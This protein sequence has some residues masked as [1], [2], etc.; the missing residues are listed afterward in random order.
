MNLDAALERLSRDPQ[1]SLDV[2]EVSLSL[3]RDE[4][5]R[6]DVE[7]CL[8]EIVSMAHEARRYV[9]GDLPG[10]VQ[11]LCRYLFHDMGFRGNVK[12]YYDPLNSYFN[13][14][15]ER[16]TGIPITLSALVMAVGRRAGLQV[17][18]IGLPGHFIVRVGDGAGSLLVDPFHGGRQLSGTDCENLVRQA[19]GAPIALSPLSLE[20]IPLGLMLRRMLNNLKGIYL[21]LEDFARAIR[22]MERM[23]QL[24]PRDAVLRRD[25]GVSLVRT[26]QPGKALDHLRYYIQEAPEA[27]D[28]KAIGAVLRDAEKRVAQ[29][30]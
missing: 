23:L 4:Y 27:D 8:G 30:N 3:A 1:A 24:N 20:P 6:L 25:L 29:W 2:A 5:P 22:I 26:G 15:L 10:R 19:T 9:R 21:G 11:G 18:G 13:Q 14:V 17:E 7:A 12:D 28:Q 16:R